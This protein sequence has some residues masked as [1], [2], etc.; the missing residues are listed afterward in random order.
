MSVRNN[1]RVNHHRINDFFNTAALPALNEEQTHWNTWAWFYFH[2]E[3]RHIQA[4]VQPFTRERK[5]DKREE[6][7][8]RGAG[9]GQSNSPNYFPGLGWLTVNSAA[10]NSCPSCQG[11]ITVFSYFLGRNQVTARS[12]ASPLTQKLV[13]LYHP[14]HLV[15]LLSDNWKMD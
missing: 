12:R 2:A 3:V 13:P 11:Q 14:E 8:T 5:I 1:M 10:V 7:M 9:W 6:R 15:V 4:E